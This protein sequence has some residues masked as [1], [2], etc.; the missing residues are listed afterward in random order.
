LW[1]RYR[2]GRNSQARNL[3]VGDNLGLVHR[4]AREAIHPGVRA[5]D[6][7]DLVGAGTVGL[8]QAIEGFDPSRG[9][10]FSTYAMPRIRGAILDELHGQD[11]APRSVRVRRRRI[12]RAEAR[13]QQQLGASPGPT[14]LAEA[15]GVD[16][17]TFWRWWGETRGR[18]IVALDHPGDETCP[19]ALQ[20]LDLIPDDG[21][22][23]ADEAM[24]HAQLL[25][26]MRRCL[27]GLPDRDRL[28]LTLYYYEGL[29]LREIGKVLG[30]SESR[31]CQVHGRA[32]RAL[33]AHIDP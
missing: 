7:G 16:L 21:V 14:Q 8:I 26:R 5:V 4:A 19:D 29:T 33:R 27:R 25:E 9:F 3:L 20:L 2:T 24:A 12:A 15:L 6:L 13:L 23:N 28:V 11:W 17:A 18:T 1:R 32:L 10:A 22:V 31:V 30:V